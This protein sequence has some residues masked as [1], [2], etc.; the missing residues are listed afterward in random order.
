[1]IY[2]SESLLEAAK[3][4][5]PKAELVTLRIHRT[6]DTFFAAQDGAFESSGYS[7]DQGFMVE[8]LYKGHIAFG[9][10]DAKVQDIMLMGQ[11]KI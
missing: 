7:A 3:N 2:T 5:V 4:A 6:R 10:M 8:V 1:M 9:V 11:L